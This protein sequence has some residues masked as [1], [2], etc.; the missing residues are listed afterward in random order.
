MLFFLYFMKSRFRPFRQYLYS[1]HSLA[2]N[3]SW[4]SICNLDLPPKPIQVPPELIKVPPVFI[5]FGGASQQRCYAASHSWTLIPVFP[6]PVYIVNNF[7]FD[8]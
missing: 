7:Y 4:L 1:T 2:Q 5:V 8:N 3:A 6:H